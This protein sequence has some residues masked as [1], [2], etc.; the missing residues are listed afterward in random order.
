[1]SSSVIQ[2][3]YFCDRPTPRPQQWIVPDFVPERHLAVLY[4]DGGAGKSY[5]ALAMALAIASG[6]H[7]LGRPVLKGPVAYL[8]FEFDQDAQQRRAE[9]VAK[10]LGLT[11]VL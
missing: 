6:T 1:M 11:S 10:G 8:D 2:P 9:A 5:L 3:V 4:G 7:W